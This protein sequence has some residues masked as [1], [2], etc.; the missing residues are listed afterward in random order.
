MPTGE[1]DYWRKF[2]P[3]KMHTDIKE[4]L[5][6]NLFKSTLLIKILKKENSYIIISKK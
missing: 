2:I 4:T 1:N 6:N 3:A 5:F